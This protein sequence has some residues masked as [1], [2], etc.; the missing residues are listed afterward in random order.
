[1]LYRSEHVDTPLPVPELSRR[2]RRLTLGDVFL[3]FAGHRSP[4][5]PVHGAIA[6]LSPGDALQVRKGSNRY[7]LLDSNGT[8]VG[9]L[10]GGFE[11]LP[12][13]RCAF[14]T[15]MAI[16]AWDRERSDPQFRGRLKCDVWEV[17]VPELV[18]ETDS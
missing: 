5:D 16:V 1:M 6:R 11:V 4:G 9:Q 8:V 7:E 3:G 13:M 15:V 2:Y 12:G 17:V 10:A 18:F 14:A